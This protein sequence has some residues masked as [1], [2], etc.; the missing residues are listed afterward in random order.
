MN[1]YRGPL[2]LRDPIV[3]PLV[4]A[5]NDTTRGEAPM[6]TQQ[7]ELHELDERSTVPELSGLLMIIGILCLVLVLAILVT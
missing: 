7:H 1:F 6:T 5:R 2:L 4:V 3:E